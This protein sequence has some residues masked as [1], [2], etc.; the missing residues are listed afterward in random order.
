[1][2]LDA[3]II[4]PLENAIAMIPGGSSPIGRSA[5]G[6]AIGAALVFGLEPGFMFKDGK[7][8][9]W[10]ITDPKGDDPTAFPWPFGVILPA[11]LLGVF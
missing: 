8:R 2:S 7:P 11:L 10:V 4:T 9:P 1:M 5:I 6:A 3:S